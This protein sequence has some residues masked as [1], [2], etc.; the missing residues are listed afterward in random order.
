MLLEEFAEADTT[1][2]NTFSTRT[3][4]VKKID[5]ILYPR[6]D[7]WEVLETKVLC[8]GDASDHCG[9]FAVLR[10]MPR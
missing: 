10:Y 8:R 6:N 9:F 7:Q 2:Q 3:G 5:F 4:L 1:Y